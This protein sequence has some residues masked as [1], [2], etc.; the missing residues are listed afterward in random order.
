MA[1]RYTLPHPIGW[2]QICYSQ[3]LAKG[4]SKAIRYFGEDMVLFRTQSGE[5][6]VLDAYCPHMGAHLGHGIHEHTGQGGEVKEETIVCPF[7]GWRFNGNGE[8]E[9]V[10]YAQNI[11]PKIV[12]KRCLKSWYVCERNKVI[13]VW[14]HP[15][16][17]APSYE[18]MEIP[19]AHD[20]DWGELQIHHWKLKT[21]TQEMAENAADPAHFHF[22][23]GTAEMP[24]Y[25]E[26]EF[27]G[28]TRRT[29][30][31]SKM[32]TPKG[33]INGEIEAFS[34][35]PG[36]GITRFSGICETVL[37][38]NVTSID[39][40][41]VDVNFA[42][43]QKK[44]NGE[45]P[46]RGV[47]AAIIADICKQLEEDAPIWENKIYRP[48]PILCDGDGPIAKFRKWFAGF[49]LDYQPETEDL[50]FKDLG[51]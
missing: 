22:V 20:D 2:F 33:I 47:N 7:H 45:V 30:I 24:N 21:H 25:A 27:E 15:N 50:R 29:L 8:C 10:P 16:G 43:I 32:K 35:G 41:Y 1:S 6:K 11:P 18:V 13:W 36:Q 26:V 28:H 49:Y 34:N 4:Q 46:T 42:F 51:L 23:H 9:D 38:G 48:L 3:D 17:E 37:M 12:G 44:I 19:E 31:K 5:A 39:D 40:E 14:Y